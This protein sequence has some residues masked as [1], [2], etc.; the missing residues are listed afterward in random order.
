MDVNGA[1]TAD[2][3]DVTGRVT[4]RTNAVGRKAR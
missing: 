4:S 1:R 2:E 3:R